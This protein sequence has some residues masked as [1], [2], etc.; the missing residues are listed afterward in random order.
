MPWKKILPLLFLG[1]LLA[2]AMARAD[3]VVYDF[4]ITQLLNYDFNNATDPST[5]TYRKGTFSL[6]DGQTPD[7]VSFYEIGPGTQTLYEMG[8]QNTAYTMKTIA[9][10]VVT[11]EQDGVGTVLFFW[12][13]IML[14][15]GFH[16]YNS[17]LPFDRSDPYHPAFQAGHYTNGNDPFTWYDVQVD[18]APEPSTLVLLGTGV[19]GAAGLLRRYAKRVATTPRSREETSTDSTEP[20][21]FHSEKALAPQLFR[22]TI[23]FTG[24]AILQKERANEELST[25]TWKGN[26]RTRKGSLR[27]RKGNQSGDRATGSRR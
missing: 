19:I 18:T 5:Y 22:S 3:G 26:Q 21:Y 4:T 13:G 16:V 15:N 10:G 8:Y 6:L 7:F 25:K 24:G 11:S 23:H 14:P 2:P 12:D 1:V 17:P 9:N 20:A 27:N